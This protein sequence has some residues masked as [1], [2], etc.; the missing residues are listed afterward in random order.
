MATQCIVRIQMNLFRNF[1]Q[2]LMTSNWVGKKNVKSHPNLFQIGLN[3]PT[4]NLFSSVDNSTNYNK[5]KM[6]LSRA[7][8]A[9][10]FG[11]K[12]IA[13]CEYKK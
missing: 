4:F 11:W 13:K 6:K 12:M 1:D 10:L 2:F 9:R 7:I 5:G 8:K 3:F